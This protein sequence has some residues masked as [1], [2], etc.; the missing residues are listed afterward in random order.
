P[1]DARLLRDLPRRLPRRRGR[2]AARLRGRLQAG[3]HGRAVVRGGG[4]RLFHRPGPAAV[5]GAGRAP[6][7]GG[8]DDMTRVA[9]VAGRPIG[10]SLSPAIHGAWVAAAGLDAV[11]HAFEPEDAAAFD[12]L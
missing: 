9:G 2:G 7:G 11:Y 10:H 6:A 8:A 4:G 12:R 3:R 5:A 1:A